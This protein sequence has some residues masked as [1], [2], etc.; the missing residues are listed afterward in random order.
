M[1]MEQVNTLKMEDEE[2]QKRSKETIDRVNAQLTVDFSAL[3]NA[4]NRVMAVTKDAAE[5][6]IKV[7]FK[8]MGIEKKEEMAEEAKAGAASGEASAREKSAIQRA[9]NGEKEAIND[10]IQEAI[11]FAASKE[12][13]AIAEEQEMMT[14]L[15]AVI[16][17]AAEANTLEASDMAKVNADKASAQK[18]VKKGEF[19][20]SAIKKELRERGKA[21]QEVH[22]TLAST[23]VT[24]RSNGKKIVKL[25]SEVDKVTNANQMLQAQLTEK[26][27]QFTSMGTK[28]HDKMI[29][30]DAL[31]G[32]LAMQ[33]KLRVLLLHWKCSKTRHPIS[34]KP[35]LRKRPQSRRLEQSQTIHSGLECWACEF[36]TTVH[37]L[38]HNQS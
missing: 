32:Q 17:K 34:R 31:K 12:Q 37:T 25:Q 35:Q 18:E 11:K 2:V 1:G 13:E 30:R 38:C 14:E 28:L 20:I 4:S 15:T 6:K 36:Q 3:V 22:A 29:L 21:L 10:A 5:A 8:A 33:Q 26:K 19:E 16:T 9:M 7:L 27:E 23:S 24:V